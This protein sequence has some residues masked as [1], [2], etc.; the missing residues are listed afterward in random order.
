MSGLPANGNALKFAAP[1]RDVR[2]GGAAGDTRL[3]NPP[4]HRLNNHNAHYKNT[5]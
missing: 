3:F 5:H 2:A 4:T 1:A